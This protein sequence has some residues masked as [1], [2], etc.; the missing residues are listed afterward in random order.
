M[1][2][3]SERKAIVIDDLSKGLNTLDTETRMPK[4][5]YVDAQNIYFGTNKNPQTVG[6]T[7]RLNTTTV[8]SGN[9]VW[10]EPYTDSAAVTTYLVA[11]TTGRLYRYTV[12]TDT[13]RLIL[14]G[15]ATTAA[16]LRWSHAPFR[17]SLWLA[18]GTD[19][20]LKWDGTNVVPGGA[21]WNA[22]AATQ[23]VADMEADEDAIWSGGT[24]YTTDTKEGTQA[25]Q[26]DT[27]GAPATDSAALTYAADRDFLTGVLGAP[28]LDANDDFEIWYRRTAGAGAT[29]FR[30]RFGNTGD[31]AYFQRTESLNPTDSNWTRLRIQRSLVPIV[32]GAPVWNIIRKFTI[33]LD[34]DEQTYQFDWAYWRYDQ[35]TDGPQ[36]GAF[37]DFYAQQLIVAGISSDKVLIRY[38]DAGTPDFFTA[39]QTARFS[40]GRH[41]GEKEDQITALRSYFD[42]LIVGKVN[43]AW[44]LSGTGAN[45]STSALPLTIGID[46]HRA[47]VETPW[48]LH[49]PFENNIF[50]SRLTSRGLVST[51]IHSL[52]QSIDGDNV[53]NSVGIRHDRTHTIRWG[54]QETGQ[55][56]NNL[57]LIYDYQH[58]AWTSVYTPAVRYYTRGIVSGNREVLIAQ[59]DGFMRRADVGTTFDGTAIA[60]FITLPWLQSTESADMG[61][62]VQWLDATVNLR[63]TASVIVE[64]RFAIEPREF[65]GATYSTYA[66]V[67][68]TP[69]ADEGF[70]YFG[71]TNRWMQ[72]RLRATSLA[73]EVLIPITIHHTTHKVRV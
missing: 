17:G 4:G 53:A 71:V 36:V 46:S 56:T 12:G 72:L 44:T 33:F 27:V 28:N 66:T 16:A 26:V 61:D 32:A 8:P 3:L 39:T 42:E 1:T 15:L 29:T 45:V 38:S 22:N 52:L 19:D 70:A 25:R 40:G 59:Y 10:F 41:I 37:I 69:D 31:T 64:A 57:G 18:N 34:T 47:I 6:G 24:I 67:G 49:F 68:A 9:V 51:N 60:S 55:T 48:S 62:V 21:M 43:S 20:I 30:L 63:G 50:G 11:T 73:F 2:V 54:F 5:F 7:T 23:L 58:D 35:D 13:W 14:T 65:A